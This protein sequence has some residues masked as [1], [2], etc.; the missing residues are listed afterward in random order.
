MK[1]RES[2]GIKKTTSLHHLFKR[3]LEQNYNRNANRYLEFFYVDYSGAY[4]RG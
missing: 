3:L 2:H 1:S 4:A